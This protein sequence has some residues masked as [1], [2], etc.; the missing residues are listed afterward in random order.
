MR[1]LKF[2]WQHSSYSLFLAFITSIVGGAANVALIALLQRVI[3]GRVQ[4]GGRAM[5]IFAALCAGVL[6]SR[7]YSQLLLTKLSQR[8]TFRLLMRICRRI[9]ATPLARLE[10]VG[11]ARLTAALTDDVTIVVAGLVSIPG[12]LTQGTVVLLC[13]GYMLWLSPPMAMVVI[14]FLT[15]GWTAIHMAMHRTTRFF[16]LAWDDRNVL[17]GHFRSLLEG[18]KELKLHAE[19]R[20][21]FMEE[22]IPAAA[23][24][25]ER[26]NLAGVG[27]FNLGAGFAQSLMFIAMALSVF[28]LPQWSGAGAFAASGF[29]IVLLYLAVPIEYLAG[30]VPGIGR[31]NLALRELESLELAAPDTPGIAQSTGWS[32]SPDERVLRLTGVTRAYRSDADNREFI[33]GPIDLS[34]RRGETVFLIGG[35]GSGKSTLAKIITGLYAPDGGQIHLGGRPVTDENRNEYCQN[36]SAVFQDYH[37]FDSLLGLEGADIDEHCRRQLSLFQ[38]DRQ[39]SIQDGRLSTLKL[40]HGQRKRLALLVAYIE[41]RPMYLFDE[42][43]A[44]QEPLFKAFFYTELLPDLKRRGKTVVVISHDDHYYSTATRL[45]KLADGMVEFDRE[46]C[47]SRS[48]ASETVDAG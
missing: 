11:Q 39:V 40:S 5:W 22:V 28:L 45:V 31:A 4:P 14:V 2:L 37:V 42:W 12:V 8:A 23:E 26:H 25:Y 33:L 15:A 20:R 36:F 21:V 10:Q 19:R 29:M 27:V 41:D 16:K 1:A 46:T 38:L 34:I 18:I 44:D 17:F 35:N 48:S 30:S 43:A 6:S 3:G 32:M 24:S 7:L 47:N 9:L 13:L